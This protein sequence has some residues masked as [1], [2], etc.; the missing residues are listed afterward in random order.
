VGNGSVS[1]KMP[2]KKKIGPKRSKI[3]LK[4]SK[5]KF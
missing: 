1:R 3:E 4:M 5:I 2:I